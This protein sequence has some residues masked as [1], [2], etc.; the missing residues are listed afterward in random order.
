MASETTSSTYASQF[1]ANLVGEIVMGANRPKLVVSGLVNEDDINGQQ[2]N[3]IKYPLYA[4]LTKA[5]AGTEGTE[6]TA[7]TALS[8]GTAVSVTVIENAL[9]RSLVT[10]RAVELAYGMASV[11]QL[12]QEGSLAQKTAIFGPE[13]ERLGF[14]CLETG[15]TDLTALL[16]SATGSVGTTT[17]PLTVTNLLTAQHTLKVQE[18]VN[19]NWAYV[20]TPKQMHQAKLEV[21]VTG[22]G[23]GGAVWSGAAD[24]SFFNHNPDMPR[25]GFRGSF[26]GIPIY[27]QSTSTVATANG[28]AD[29]VGALMCVGSGK[30]GPASSTGFLGQTRRGGIKVRYQYLPSF[31]GS[32]LIVSTECKSFVARADGA[33]AIVTVV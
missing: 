23:L 28:A 19:E 25:N 24:A 2:A 10:D 14:A 3:V 22:G 33:V 17:T 12:M 20:L 29:G 8:M 31:R 30:P 18:P 11:E 7:N 15:E 32:L 21:G 9:I 1:L 4:D 27:E 13:L 16:A 5:S 26:M 6:I